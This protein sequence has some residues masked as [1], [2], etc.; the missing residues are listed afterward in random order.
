[1]GHIEI[2]VSG[3]IQFEIALLAV[4]PDCGVASTWSV[5]KDAGSVG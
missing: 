1:M 5:D 4:P 2:T 3:I